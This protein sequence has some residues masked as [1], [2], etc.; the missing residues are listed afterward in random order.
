[1]ANVLKIW[2]ATKFLTR[3]LMDSSYIS[4]FRDS[5]PS[6][7]LHSYLNYIELLSIL[8]QKYNPV[9]TKTDIGGEKMKREEGRWNWRWN[10]I[11]I[12]PGK[13]CDHDP[14][15]SSVF[16]FETTISEKQAALKQ[17][18]KLKLA[19]KQTDIQAFFVIFAFETA[20]SE[21]VVSKNN[22]KKINYK[23]IEIW[24]SLE[25]KTK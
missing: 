12:L 23:I 10:T 16:T 9:K 22:T 25:D 15:N 20:I 24:S 14:D 13:V 6:F 1:M 4:H 8:R 5:T 17:I 18:K 21:T 3:N 2:W 19:N 11:C 7:F